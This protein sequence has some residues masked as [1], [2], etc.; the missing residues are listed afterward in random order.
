MRTARAMKRTL[1]PIVHDPSRPSGRGMFP[2]ERAPCWGGPMSQLTRRALLRRKCHICV[3]AVTYPPWPE[4]LLAD[5]KSTCSP[6]CQPRS[7]S[8][9]REMCRKS[10]VEKSA[11]ARKKVQGASPGT[12]FWAHFSD[13]WRDQR[14]RE[15][16]DG[17]ETPR[18]WAGASLYPYLPSWLPLRSSRKSPQKPGAKARSSADKSPV[19]NPVNAVAVDPSWMPLL[20]GTG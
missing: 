9:V 4:L 6:S 17:R 15:R 14:R 20:G 5:W 3:A 18:R 10:P 16:A 19:C 2:F 8:R 12:P 1:R 13:L 11:R 7:R